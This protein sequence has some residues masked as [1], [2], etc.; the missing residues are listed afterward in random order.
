MNINKELLFDKSK[1]IENANTALEKNLLFL[2]DFIAPLSK[3]GPNDF[4]SNGDYWWPNPE[5]SNGLPY[6]A[7]YLFIKLPTISDVFHVSAY[8]IIDS[9]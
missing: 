8:L 9:S 5:T 1:I 6:L 2:T 4:Y 7:K 3:G